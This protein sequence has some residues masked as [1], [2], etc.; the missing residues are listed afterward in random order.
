MSNCPRKLTSPRVWRTYTGGKLIDAIHGVEYGKDGQFPEEWIISVVNARNVGREHILDEG[1]CYLADTQVSLRDYIDEDPQGILGAA[2]ME[3]VGKTPGVLV[4]IIDAAERLTVHAHPD[5]ERAL[6]LFHSP[7][8]KTECW[9][10]LGGREVDGQQPCIYLGFKEGIT[11]EYWK[12]CF[13]L[14]DIPAMLNCL[15]QFPVSA[16][17]TYLIPGGVPHAIGAGCLLIEIQEPTDYT[18]RTERVTPSGLRIK[19]Q[20]CHQG[21]GFER[22]FDCFAYEGLSEQEARSRFVIP[23][24]CLEASANF[25]QMELVGSPRT[26]CFRLERYEILADTKLPHKAVMSGLYI[27]SGRGKLVSESSTVKFEAGE[28]F[29][30]AADCGEISLIP[31]EPVILF[32]CYGPKLKTE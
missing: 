5:K 25:T 31:E 21:L 4:K 8:G 10:I 12:Q 16:G 7:F 20:Q 24:V 27:I 29:F 3:Q 22:M 23:P 2:H 17:Q 9:H 11:R 32:R 15:N 13:D 30:V 26:D 28:Q 18:V 6:E 14:Q 19:D 1:L